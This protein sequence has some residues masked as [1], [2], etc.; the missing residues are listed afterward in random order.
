MMKIRQAAFETK[1]KMLK[2]NLHCH[3]T[4]SDGS[5]K[6]ED[7][8]EQFEAADYDFLSLTDHRFYNYENF[9]EGSELLIIPGMEMDC[10]LPG[11]G[12]HCIHTVAIGPEK[13]NGNGY[14]QDERLPSGVY[15]KAED[16]QPMFDDIVA[17]NNLSIFC[18]PNWSGNTSAEVQAVS[19]YSMIEV[20]NS[21]CALTNETD[22]SAPYWDELLLNGKKIWGV[23]TDDGHPVKDHCHGWVRVNA[24]KNVDSIL[25]ALKRGAFYASAGPEIYDF[26]VEDGVATVLCS[27][28]AKVRFRHFRVPYPTQYGDNIVGASQKLRE[29]ANYIRAEVVDAQGHVA[30][31]NPIFLEW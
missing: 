4:R 12:I 26:F 17:H 13:E 24:E 5:G 6:P 22:H 1:R 20:W 25:D 16:A 8:I 28:C 23:A 27:P 31:T 29:G 10:R 14:E 9:L 21:G 3:T 18:H 2:G 15:E 19:G 30:W 7:V 11:P